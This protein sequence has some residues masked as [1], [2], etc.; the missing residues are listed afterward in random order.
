ME[1]ARDEPSRAAGVASVLFRASAGTLGLDGA[2][3]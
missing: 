3:F 1:P 2:F